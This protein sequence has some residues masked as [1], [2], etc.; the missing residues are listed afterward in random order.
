MTA[1][2]LKLLDIRFELVIGCFLKTLGS[3]SD[4]KMY[5]KINRIFRK[6]KIEIIHASYKR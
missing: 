5:Y 3:R 2:F 1:L 6:L 4:V